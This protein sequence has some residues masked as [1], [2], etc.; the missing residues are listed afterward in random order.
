MTRGSLVRG[1]TDHATHR[2][3]SGHRNAIMY[4][5]TH[6]P[7]ATLDGPHTEVS[8]P[9]GCDSPRLT[10]LFFCGLPS[11]TTPIASSNPCLCRV[12][13]G[14]K[15]KIENATGGG[16][17]R[18]HRVRSKA[19]APDTRSVIGGNHKT[20]ADQ[21]Q[22]QASRAS[23]RGGR[24]VRRGRASQRARPRRADGNR[25]GQGYMSC[26]GLC[27]ALCLSQF[28]SLRARA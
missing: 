16:P 26:T 23:G 7:F 8:M 9:A 22:T 21:R 1:E 15:G 10:C 4:A 27:R 20:N 28:W 14:G 17:K 13:G 25:K 11:M 3:W 12:H 5:S 2:T 19:K 6:N 24:D 18:M